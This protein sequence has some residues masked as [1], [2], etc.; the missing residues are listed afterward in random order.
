MYVF[1]GFFSG[2]QLKLQVLFQNRGSSTNLQSQPVVTALS[3]N[4]NSNPNNNNNSNIGTNKIT[5]K[6][7]NNN[8]K[9]M[10]LI[11]MYCNI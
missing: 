8:K 6:T 4:F 3:N 2:R 9:T 7:E 10:I 5:V 1:T 11:L